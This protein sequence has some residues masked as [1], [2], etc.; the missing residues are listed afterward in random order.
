MGIAGRCV[1]TQDEIGIRKHLIIFVSD[2]IPVVRGEKTEHFAIAVNLT[3]LKKRPGKKSRQ[4]TTTILKSGDHPFITRDSIIAYE[5]ARI[6]SK[7]E[8]LNM[9]KSGDKREDLS[10]SV[11]ARIVAGLQKSKYTRF[12]VRDFY[13]RYC[14]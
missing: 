14:I 13:N 5:Y 9:L 1:L 7:S 11:L 2:F 3:T 10:E 12:E 8:A 4:D 6:V